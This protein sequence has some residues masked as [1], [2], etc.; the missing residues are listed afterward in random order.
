MNNDDLGVVYYLGNIVQSLNY[1]VDSKKPYIV[2][3][4]DKSTEKHIDI[5]SRYP[6]VEFH[7]LKY[8]STIVLYLKSI[9]RQKNYFINH[10][11]HDYQLDGIMPVNDM[12]F[13]NSVEKKKT[14][15]WITDFQHKFYPH[16]FSRF[17][18][19]IRE[20]RFS[21]SLRNAD[22]VIL[23]SQDAK[24]HLLQFYKEVSAELRVLHFV[25]FANNVDLLNVNA[26]KQ[27]Y[28]IHKPYFIVSNQ[29]YKHK[30]H[31]NNILNLIFAQNSQ[32]C[33]LKLKKI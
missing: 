10:L 20:F 18:R 33:K 22:Y 4:Y 31:Q 16:F 11:L 3:F 24:T 8:P 12:I 5:F 30:N 23:S 7:L 14:I 25:S 32:K 15:A 19:I 26:I 1:L 17:N 28:D 9:I 29:F 27:K 21:N 2:L 6:H 13:K